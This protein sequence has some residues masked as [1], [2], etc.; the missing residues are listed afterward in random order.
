MF[1]ILFRRFSGKGYFQEAFG[2][3]CVDFGWSEGTLGRDIGDAL[4]LALRKPNL[5]PINDRLSHYNEADLFD[6]IEFLFDHTSKPEQGWWHSYNNCGLH[7]ETF[8]QEPART[9]YRIELNEFLSDYG[10]GYELSRDGEVRYIGTKG[11]D[12]LFE[13]TIPHLDSGNVEERVDAAIQKFRRRG[14]SLEDR[15]DAVRTLADVLEYLRPQVKLVITRQDEADLFQIA[16][17]FGIRHHDDKQKTEY[18]RSLWLS[19]MFHYYLAT[20]HFCVR[21]IKQEHVPSPS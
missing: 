11:L 16:N 13:T 10:E 19:W 3:T 17:Q 6:I 9:E 15:H 1:G 20:I 4:L 2:F 21:R 18:D 8:E 14:T 12:T 5:W 7:P